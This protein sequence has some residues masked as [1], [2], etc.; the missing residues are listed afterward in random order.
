[1][2]R[3]PSKRVWVLEWSDRETGAGDLELWATQELAQARRGQLR[4]MGDPS[5]L[6]ASIHPRFVRDATWDHGQVAR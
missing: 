1:M 2:K 3:I 5:Q 4:A 6:K